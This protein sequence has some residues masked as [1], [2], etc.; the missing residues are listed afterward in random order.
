MLANFFGKSKPIGALVILI[1]FLCFYALFVF[2]ER[3][4]FDFWGFILILLTF[5]LTNFINIKNELTFDNYYMYLIFVLLMTLFPKTFETNTSFYA[6]I[7]VLLSLRRAY[8]LQSEKVIFK[9]LFDAGLWL[10]ISF[11][12]E[13]F[14]LI[15]FLFIYIA[16]Y[17][18]IQLTI[19]TLAIPL[20]GFLIPVFLYFTYCFWYEKTTDF[21]NLFV[22]FTDYNFTLYKNA[23][24]L[25]SILFIVFFIVA[26]VVLKTPEALSVKNTF[27]LSWKLVILNLFLSVLLII[28]TNN[29]NGTEILYALFPASIIIANGIEIYQKKW[30][31]DVVILLFFAGAITAYFL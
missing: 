8:S 13:P 18:H 25:F 15:F 22:W 11:V 27:R 17:F 3:I 26:S 5:S 21:Y 2:T 24:Y 12:I 28:V 1:L 29:R 7:A 6:N 4:S 31:S 10:G 9:K 20:I 14:T 30:I 16:V 19:R 23:S